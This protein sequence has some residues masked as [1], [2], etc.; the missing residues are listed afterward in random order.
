MLETDDEVVGI[1]D[2]DHVARGLLPSPAFGPEI[3]DIVEIDVR[4]Q[5]RYHRALARSRFLDRHDPVFEDAG[6]QPFLYEPQDAPIADPVLQEADDPL[7]GNFREERPNV[8]VENEVHLPAADPD[9]QRVQ[10]IMLAAPWPEPIREPEEI[11]LVD[12][13]QHGRRGPLEDLVFQG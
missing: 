11:F 9:N 2:H 5:W 1:P 8:G 10:R 4:E 7:L 12:H 13:A 6:S 3:E